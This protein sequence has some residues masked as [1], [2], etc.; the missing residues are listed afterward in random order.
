MSA[1]N[2]LWS[3]IITFVIGLAVP[4]AHA[5]NLIGLY[6]GGAAGHS[7]IRDETA[8]SGSISD[9]SNG[10]AVRVGIKPIP[11][12]GVEAE[13]ADFGNIKVHV[14]SL[15]A[16]DYSLG[17]RSSA[18][19][20]VLYIPNP[21]PKLDLLIKAGYSNLKQTKNGT[22]TTTIPGVG[23]CAIGN[24]NCATMTFSGT[25]SQTN[26][27]VAYG[28]GLQFTVLKL[29]FRAEYER[30]HNTLGDPDMATLGVAVK[31]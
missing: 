20:A 11:L 29:M 30:I 27:D 31:F 5:D 4:Q 26:S 12:I 25:V 13:Y 2:K 8:A 16:T 7:T 24:P 22:W 19:F 18:A 6:I 1:L 28:A 23:T 15:Q 10:W 9:S 17:V 3:V 21:V 14:A